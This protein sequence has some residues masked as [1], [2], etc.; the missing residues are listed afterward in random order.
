MTRP[1]LRRGSPAPRQTIGRGRLAALVVAGVGA[2]ALSGVSALTGALD[3][4]ERASI[5]ARF[6][7]RHVSPPS[8]IVVVRIDDQSIGELQAFPFPRSLHGRMID[9]LH[10]AGVREIVYDVQFTEPSKDW[11]QDLALYDAIG[12]AGGATLATSQSDAHG[13]TNVLGGDANLAKVNARA[14]AANLSGSA[15]GVITHFP[16]EVSGLRSLAAVSA[17]RALGK[18]MSPAQFSHGEALIDFRGG[19]G[20]FASYPF[21]RVLR[22]GVPD[23]ALRGK[24]VVV[25][26]TAPSLQDLHATPTSGSDL[27]TGPEV[28]ANAIWTAL[29]GNPLRMAP[30]WWA[31]LAVIIGALM[32]PL[33]ALRLG[34][35][36]AAAISVVAAGG[37]AVTAQLTFGHGI[38]IAVTAPLVACGLG[39][40]G[41]L[42]AAYFTASS[43]R[44]TLGWAV[45]R[46]TEQLRDA[47][48]EIITRLAQA[49]ESRDGDTGAHIHRMGYL[50]ERL[51]LQVGLD[52]A[53]ANML[54]HASALH[55]VGKIGVP[56]GVLLKPGALEADEWT[57]MQSHTVKGAEI[58]AGS[59]SPLIQMAETIA[60]THHERWDGTGYPNGLK[61]E[62]IPLEGR[63]CAICDVYDALGSKRPYKEAWSPERV[64]GE[65]AV[66]AGSHFDPALVAAFL[67]LAPLLDQDQKLDERDDVDLETLPPLFQPDDEAV[68]PMPM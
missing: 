52:P 42:A 4:L 29:H 13:K 51:A 64:I 37:Y 44:R 66:G 7:A 1:T 14:A 50:C 34:V 3:S 8:D 56:D 30:A 49:A 23:S 60:R 20:T 67:E 21:S 41:M 53:R 16:Y 43:D 10:A 40:A 22:G 11:R 36:K 68:G 28:Q 26:A 59:T 17:E 61:G 57:V 62:E 45:R 33:A 5:A 27:M 54:R 2:L 25:G 39:T 18:P 35:V 63:I 55:D 12:A 46:R 32:A 47:Q 6:A 65:I 19:P 15:G 24:I 48:F 38:V 9:R 58:L 31:V